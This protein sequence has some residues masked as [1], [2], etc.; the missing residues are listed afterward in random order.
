MCYQPPEYF[1]CALQPRVAGA[2]VLKYDE[3]AKSPF[4]KPYTTILHPGEASCSFC[5]APRVREKQI[6]QACHA[7]SP[8][9]AK[10]PWQ[11]CR[12]HAHSNQERGLRQQEHG[13][14]IAGCAVLR[15]D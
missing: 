1:S 15:A 4:I 5:R 9:A 6:L 3:K 11:R 13:T 14:Y 10:F 7:T 12:G 2:E 8:N